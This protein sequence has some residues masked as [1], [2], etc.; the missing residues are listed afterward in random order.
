MESNISKDGVLWIIKYPTAS[1]H[2]TYKSSN[3]KGFAWFNLGKKL[4]LTEDKVQMFLE[5]NNI[6]ISFHKLSFRVY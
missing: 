1:F 2:E 4:F 3:Q 5:Y 6:Y